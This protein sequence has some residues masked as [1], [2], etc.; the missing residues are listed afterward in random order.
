MRHQQL[1]SAERFAQGFAPLETSEDHW[2]A[3]QAATDQAREQVLGP[4]DS[5]AHF[6]LPPVFAL[7]DYMS[8]AAHTLLSIAR[9]P[10]V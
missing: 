2:A 6:R 8:T 3:A 4:H 5:E 10:I 9:A 1:I 7:A